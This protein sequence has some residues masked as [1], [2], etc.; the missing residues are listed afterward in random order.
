MEENNKTRQPVF[1]P[2]MCPE[3]EL[4][5]P[6]DQ[7]DD[8]ICDCRPAHI[9]QP[10]TDKCWPAYRKGPCEE[11]HYLVLPP[12]SFIPVCEKN[13]CRLDSF[14]VFNDKCVQLG[15]TVPCAHSYPNSVALG[16]NATTLQVDCVKLN[17]EPKIFAPT[18]NAPTITCPPGC[19]RDIHRQCLRS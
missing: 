8:W 15:S 12:N 9:Y 2:S 5:Y 10:A 11:E 18:T 3:N 16:V 17:F 19:K 6:G 13:P 4:Y 1:L 14:V 7:K